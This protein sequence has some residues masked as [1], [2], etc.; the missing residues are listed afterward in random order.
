LESEES[1]AGTED[2]MEFDEVP[3]DSGGAGG[4]KFCPRI[5]SNAMKAIP[6]MLAIMLTKVR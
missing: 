5:I 6:K 3:P 1:F 2:G 4:F